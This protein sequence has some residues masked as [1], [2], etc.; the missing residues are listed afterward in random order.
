MITQKIQ[1]FIYIKQYKINRKEAKKM[2]YYGNNC[3]ENI[4]MCNNDEDDMHCISLTMGVDEPAFC[5][6]C[7]CN[8]EWIWKFYYTSRSDYEKVKLCIIDALY[9]CNS[10][11]ELMDLLDEVF[12]EIFDDMLVIEEECECCDH[13]LS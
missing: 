10:M 1:D 12:L 2:I 9:E 3:T 8:P 7:C 11:Y 5:V 13:C 6:T 4:I